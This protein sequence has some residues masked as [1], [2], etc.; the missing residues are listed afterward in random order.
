M[1]YLS[2]FKHAQTKQAKRLDLRIQLRRQK[3]GRR[4]HRRVAVSLRSRG[5]LRPMHIQYNQFAVSKIL[6]L[7]IQKTPCI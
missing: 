1:L 3:H 2:A 5:A 6:I 7:K 4:L